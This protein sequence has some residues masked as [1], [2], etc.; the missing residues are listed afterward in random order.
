MKGL[1]VKVL[2]KGLNS[3]LIPGDVGKVMWKLY[4][5]IEIKGLEVKFQRKKVMALKLLSMQW[6]Q[7]VRQTL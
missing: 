6:G 7:F 4:L 5:T 1:K 2:M 3:S